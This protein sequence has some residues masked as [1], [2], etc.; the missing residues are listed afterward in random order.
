M[1]YKVKEIQES[2]N[3]SVNLSKENY[4]SRSNRKGNIKEIGSLTESINSLGEKLNSQDLLRGRLILDI[5]HEIRIRINVLKN[6]VGG[7]IFMANKRK[8][9]KKQMASLG[10]KKTSNGDYTYIDPEDKTGSYKP[11]RNKDNK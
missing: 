2:Q 4:N 8:V 6:N 10:L 9:T 5:S 11:V 1:K 7:V 3:T